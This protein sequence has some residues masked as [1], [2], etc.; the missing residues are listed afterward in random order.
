MSG[1]DGERFRCGEAVVVPVH[2]EIDIATAD[3]TRDR[4]LGE[5]ARTDCAC[6]VVDLSRVEFF[7]ASGRR[8][9]MAA[10]QRLTRDGRHMV[11]A[12]PAPAVSRV[13]DVLGLSGSFEVYPLVEMALAHT[14][15]SARQAGAPGAAEHRTGRF[16]GME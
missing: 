12:E 5:A 15:A 9:L 8:A 2:G 7:D 14:R 6:M 13:I 3:D 4:L 11:L 1:R 16:P 10:Y